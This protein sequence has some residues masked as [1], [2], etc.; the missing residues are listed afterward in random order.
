ME[1]PG[2]TEQ[3]PLTE[4]VHQFW[5]AEPDQ[6]AAI[7]SEVRRWLAPLPLT[8]QARLD[9]LLAVSEAATNA[10]EHAY[11]PD[12]ARES[13]EVS[14]WTDPLTVNIEVV[15]HGKWRTP[16]AQP[17]GRGLGIPLMQRLVDS[18]MIHLD[19]RGT[20]VLFTHAL[21]GAARQLPP[22]FHLPTS[23]E[24]PHIGGDVAGPQ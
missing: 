4:F 17:N 22:G 6:L 8:L 9:L 23:L 16:S 10:I 24:L 2:S 11:L 13:V 5:P 3:A 21:P 14:F 1:D 7:R 15:D 18:V 19:G 20:R 12:A